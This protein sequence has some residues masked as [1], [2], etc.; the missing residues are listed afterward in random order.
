[1]SDKP[2]LPDVHLTEELCA[3]A[4]IEHRYKSPQC[5][6]HRTGTDIQS[7]YGAE[8]R[9]DKP[10]SIKIRLATGQL[11]DLCEDHARSLG[12]D[13]LTADIGKE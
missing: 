3:D 10:A 12:L 1:M 9:C 4:A 7:D 6:R 11:Y 13:E 5:G 2:N 8:V